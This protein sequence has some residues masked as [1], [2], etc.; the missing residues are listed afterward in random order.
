ML[1]S[2]GEMLA[3][4]G[5]KLDAILELLRGNGGGARPQ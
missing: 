1:A 3:S 2:H 5:E 4:H